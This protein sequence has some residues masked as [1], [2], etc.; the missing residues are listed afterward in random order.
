MRRARNLLAYD[1][2]KGLLTCL[3]DF[4]LENLCRAYCCCSLRDRTLQG[5]EP[6]LEARKLGAGGVSLLGSECGSHNRSLSRPSYLPRPSL[7]GYQ[8]LVC[9]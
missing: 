6:G 5:E 8:G 7:S 9:P 3:H 1:L 2:Q 4:S